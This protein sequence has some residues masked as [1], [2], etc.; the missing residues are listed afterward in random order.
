M[1]ANFRLKQRKSHLKG[2]YLPSYKIVR[3]RYPPFSIGEKIK[4]PSQL[5]D[6]KILV[7]FACHTNSE[8]KLPSVTKLYALVG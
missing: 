7:I 1:Y 6:K 3:E 4:D 8:I 5:S 2:V